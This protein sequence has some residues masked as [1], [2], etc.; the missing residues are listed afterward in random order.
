MILTMKKAAV[1]V[2]DDSR[3]IIRYPSGGIRVS[4]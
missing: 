2:I 3:N 1:T 4:S